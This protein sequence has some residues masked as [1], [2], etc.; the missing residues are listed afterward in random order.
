MSRRFSIDKMEPHRRTMAI[1][2]IRANRHFSLVEIIANL[3]ELGITEISKSALHRYLPT[4]DKKDSLCASPNEGTIVTI[5]ERGTGEV[6]T[7]ASS[8]S[9]RTIAEMVKGLQLPS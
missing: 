1:D 6:I 9:G 4:L 3:R 5:V 7:L 8:A 2:C